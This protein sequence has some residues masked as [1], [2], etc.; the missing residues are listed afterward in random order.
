MKFKQGDIVIVN[1]P[2]S[3]LTITKKRPAL[4][5]SNR[6]IN[7][8]GDYLLV[9]IT[10]KNIPDYLTYPLT[11]DSFVNGI[12]L[13]LESYLRLHK[14][15]LLNQSLIVSKLNEFKQ[16]RN[17]YYCW[18]NYQVDKIRF[19]CKSYENLSNDALFPELKRVLGF[20]PK[21]SV[22]LQTQAGYEIAIDN[23]PSDFELWVRTCPKF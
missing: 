6:K 9:Q 2:F 11:N 10:S 3:D 12:G 23:E 16:K 7:N 15:F 17:I 21:D 20:L 14:V 4:V 18:R 8:T 22:K 5:I 19:K 13:P 1:F